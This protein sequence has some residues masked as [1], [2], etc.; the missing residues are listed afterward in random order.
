MQ[1]ES[2]IPVRVKREIE[3]E[4]EMLPFE[5]RRHTPERRK[6]RTQ[7]HEEEEK[8]MAEESQEP[9]EATAPKRER[10][11]PEEEEK[12]E[13]STWSTKQLSTDRS[14]LPGA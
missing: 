11:V 4:E 7:A 12:P 10:E 13:V 2:R 6:G 14:I 1:P 9:S 3:R 8:K 5:E